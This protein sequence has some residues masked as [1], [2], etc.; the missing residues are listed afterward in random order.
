MSHTEQ[1]SDAR[2][3]DPIGSTP[4]PPPP[5]ASPA[6][7]RA[8][9]VARAI[10]AP[11]APPNAAKTAASP[12]QS[13]VGG[14]GLPP[15][16][17]S[18]GN[19]S[20]GGRWRGASDA[21]AKPA[22]G[23]TAKPAASRKEPVGDVG[24]PSEATRPGSQPP[25]G[26]SSAS[27]GSEGSA[28]GDEAQDA[29]EE[30][31]PG[32][33]D[34]IG[35]LAPPWLVSTIVH[36][37]LLLILALIT[38]PVGQG[39]SR[40]MLD[41]GRSERGSA[42]ELTEFAIETDASLEEMSESTDDEESPVEVDLPM[43]FE[44]VEPIDPVQPV[45]VDLG[46]GPRLVETMPMF[47]GR[48][49]AMKQALLAMYGG[50]PQTQDAVAMGLA[51]LKRNQEKAGSWSMRGPYS[52]GSNSENRVAAT[53]MALLAF[54]GDGHTHFRG[55]YSGEVERGLKFLVGR[56]Q[57]SGQFAEPR[58]RDDEAAYAQAQASIAICEAYAMTGDSWLREPAQ[59]ALNFAMRAQSPE[60]GWRYRPRFDSDLSVT[61]WY[62]MA[63]QSGKSAGLDVD[64]SV[65]SNVSHFLDSV[66]DYDGAAYRYMPGRPATD[67]MTAEG[68]LCRQYLG[69]PRTHPPMTQ[70]AKALAFDYGFDI[71]DNNVYYWYYATQ[72]LHHY[73][74]SPWREWNTAMREQLPKA[75]VSRGRESGS[76][77][78]Q[79][80]RWGR[81]A[82][83]LYTTCLSIY[84]LEVYYRHLPLYSSDA[85]DDV[86]GADGR[87]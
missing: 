1:S 62:M 38:T 53:A 50:T 83:R 66:Q 27:E 44:S 82:G 63:L 19:V 80:D 2:H 8:A 60:G 5:R 78:P 11:P 42:S 51:W 58:P 35:K 47:S 9:P 12:P 74:G 26:P 61:G 73:G 4:P 52:D 24:R 31:S 23:P 69:W 22:A 81:S 25:A 72:V 10:P 71:R 21:A 68:L 59:L 64:P 14:E 84:C 75:Q 77:A 57:R 65:L 48:S 3:R 85:P 18:A 32:E 16:A 17:A 41:V 33:R 15:V 34:R 36:L 46:T 29:G 76:W 79:A 7:V 20:P 86:S 55:E 87:R 43:I 39:L 37:I 30:T 45:P 54:L 67:A 70:G 40:V 49:G 28:D 56:Q 6:P 13:D